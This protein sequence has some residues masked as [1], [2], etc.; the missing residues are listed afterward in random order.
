VRS[1]V[2]LSSFAEQERLVN[3]RHERSTIP[4]IAGK[5]E[6]DEQFRRCLE[7]G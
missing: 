4:F 2:L 7:I 5:G 6:I 3:L 1:D